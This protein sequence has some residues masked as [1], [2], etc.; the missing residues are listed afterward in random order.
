MNIAIPITISSEQRA[1]FI[2]HDGKSRLP[3]GHRLAHRPTA[4]VQEM[5]AATFG[6]HPRLITGSSRDQ[7]HVWPRWV[8]MYLTRIVLK[9]SLPSIGEAFGNRHHT[10]VLHGLRKVERRIAD[11]SDFRGI[12]EEMRKV[13]EA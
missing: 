4:Q 8:A 5:V 3:P 9:R 7:H 12:V 6:I 13:L 1:Y 10:S 11:D 2:P